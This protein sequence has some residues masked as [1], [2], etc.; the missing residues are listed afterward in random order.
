VDAGLSY[1]MSTGIFTVV[2][3]GMFTISYTN[4]WDADVSGARLSAIINGTVAVAVQVGP[5]SGVVAFVHASQ[6]S[7]FSATLSAGSSFYI[8]GATTDNC[9][10]LGSSIS[11]NRISL[12]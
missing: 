11:I 4:F 1:N 2:T 10:M 12:G 9:N 5:S 3:G 8:I 6:S 7:S